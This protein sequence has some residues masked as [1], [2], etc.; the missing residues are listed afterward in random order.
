MSENW[1]DDDLILSTGTRIYANQTLISISYEKST[2]RQ[3]YN[4]VLGEG[5]DGYIH[6]KDY[7]DKTND[8]DPRFTKEELHELCNIMIE[9]WLGFRLDVITGKIPTK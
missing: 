8:Y 1:D 3:K 6:L 7:N 5:Y 2:D 9:R 4:I